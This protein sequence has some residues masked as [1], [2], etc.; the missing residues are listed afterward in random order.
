MKTAANSHFLLSAINS[1]VSR[2]NERAIFMAALDI[3]DSAERDAYLDASCGAEPGLRDRLAALIDSHERADKFLNSPPPGIEITSSRLFPEGSGDSVG[4]Y[5]LRE[6][7][8]EGGFGL[9]YVAEQEQPIRRKVALKVIKPGMDSKEVIARFEAERQALALMEHPNI[10]NVIDAATTETG[11][12]YFVMELV[13]GL[14]ITDYCDQAKLSLRERLQL[15]ITVC[16]AVQHAHQK[17]I[18]HR[19]LKPSNLMITLHDGKPVPKVIDFGVAKALNQRLTEHSLYTR[20]AQMLG[21]PMYMSPE[22]AELSEL[23]VD[24]RS[25]VYALGVL[26]YELL[27]GQ[28]PFD[29]EQFTSRGYDEMRRIVREVEPA[30]PSARVSTLSGEQRSTVAERRSID[31]RQHSRTLKG[32]LDWIVMQALEKDR[33][34]RFG[35]ADALAADL[36]R[37]LDDRPIR[38]CPPSLSYRLRKYVWRNRVLLGAIGL[39]LTTG[40]F[41]AVAAV[42]LFNNH[43]EQPGS[44]VSVLTAAAT[45]TMNGKVDAAETPSHRSTVHPS[46]LAGLIPEPPQRPDLKR[47]QLITRSPRSFVHHNWK[48]AWSPDSRHIAFGDGQFVRIYSIPDFELVR[49]LAGHT[50]SVVAVHWSS[51][52]SQVASA[53]VDNTV[54]LWDAVTGEPGP[55]LIGHHGRVDAIAWHPGGQLLASGAR[56]KTVRLWTRDG[57]TGQVLTGHTDHVYSVAWNREGSQLASTGADGTVRLWGADG[58]LERVIDAGR[59][60]RTVA[61]SPDGGRL[62][63]IPFSNGSA[64]TWNLDGTAGEWK[65]ELG[66]LSS[67]AAWSPNGKRIA[68]SHWDNRVRVWNVDGTAGLVLSG[69]DSDVYFVQWSPDGQWL[70]SGGGDHAIRLWTADGDPGPVLTGHR[71]V[72]SVSWRPDGQQFAAGMGDHTIRLYDADGTETQVLPEQDRP[73]AGIDWSLDGRQLA[74]GYVDGT[75]RVWNPDE[76]TLEPWT[77]QFPTEIRF[78]SWSSQS[79]HFA[80]TGL[81]DSIGLWSRNGERVDELRGHRHGLYEVAWNPVDGRMASVS[82]DGTLRVWSAQGELE[83]TVNVGELLASVAW[84]PDGEQLASG[85]ESGAIQL[86]WPDGRPGPLLKGHQERVASIAW[87]SDRRWIAS[88]GRDATVRLW[89]TAGEPVFVFRGHTANTHSV[90][91]RPASAEILSAGHDGTVRLWNAESRICEWTLAILPGGETIKISRNGQSIKGGAD[92]FDREFAYI[93]EQATGAME[94]LAPQEFNNRTEDFRQNDLRAGRHLN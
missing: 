67:S 82:Q 28:A 65:Q 81:D 9:V 10:A 16:Q 48:F 69:H 73:V 94:I 64:Q 89:T 11:R 20:H 75:I 71:H 62:L 8:G 29:R 56:D 21:T 51:D 61:W 59:D 46:V 41:A 17:G 63:T 1:V 91:W 92:V 53:S 44:A 45:T 3:D 4:P 43:S 39:A 42:A 52:G 93:V 87:S 2:M 74:A 33:T 36:Q 54:R 7:I 22:Q 40:N 6:L 84:R 5:K 50:N 32:E 86:W 88:G 19:D 66:G 58:T 47:W 30:R 57:K 79:Q 31:E 90:R 55:V 49:V 18:I 68:T 83:E 78:V 23:D 35:S 12:P 72:A 60:H 70:A 80:V 24:T 77:A 38:A 13:R 26:L 27:T 14:P 34:R 15:F 37:F 25:D 76:G 85:S